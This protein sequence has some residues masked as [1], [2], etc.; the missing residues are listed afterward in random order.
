MGKVDDLS[1]HHLYLDTNVFIYAKEG[2][3]EHL[4]VARA[5]FALID[6]GACTASTSEL[7][8]AEALVMPIRTGDPRQQEEYAAMVTTSGHLSVRP[9]TRDLLVA[10][11]GLR[12]SNPTIK[13]PDAIHAATALRGGCSHFVTNDARFQILTGIDVVILSELST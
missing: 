10:A 13:L 4:A 11:A 2:V 12:A 1:G 6:Q 7:S 9:I 8:L 5:L 3:A